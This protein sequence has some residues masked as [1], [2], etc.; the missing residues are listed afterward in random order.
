MNTVNRRIRMHR[1][2][3]FLLVAT[4]S[5][6]LACGG[7][8]LVFPGGAL[9]GEHVS[10]PVDDWSFADD[11]F[12]DVETRPSNPYSVELNYIVRDGQLYI[13]PAEGRKWLTYIREDPRL[14]V[15]FDDRV[16]PVTAV[17][18]GGPGEVEGFDEDRFVYRLESRPE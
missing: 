18:V 12:I 17:L 10:A 15:R 3:P 4:I 6:L 8:M 11:P 7:P 14:R 1:P 16:Y 13:D 5:G 2:V 9:S